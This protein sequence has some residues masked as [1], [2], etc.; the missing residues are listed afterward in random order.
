MA[1]PGRNML[2]PLGQIL[3]RHISDPATVRKIMRVAA[4]AT[5]TMDFIKE[6]I[7]MG[8]EAAD[9]ASDVQQGIVTGKL[10]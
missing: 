10:S 1:A 4:A 6:A 5:D 8:R 7:K 9:V 2:I 3:Q